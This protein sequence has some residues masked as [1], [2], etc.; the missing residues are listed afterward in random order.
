MNKRE[1]GRI[2]FSVLEI[3]GPSE[4]GGIKE[5]SVAVMS[6]CSTAFSF[7]LPDTPSVTKNGNL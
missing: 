6:L 4:I 2:C 3:I 7:E 5:I 1:K